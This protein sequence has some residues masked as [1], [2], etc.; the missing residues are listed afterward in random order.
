MTAIEIEMEPLKGNTAP[1]PPHDETQNGDVSNSKPVKIFYLFFFLIFER[2]ILISLLVVCCMT[3]VFRHLFKTFISCPKVKERE[4]QSMLSV[5]PNDG[6]TQ[7]RKTEAE[8]SIRHK[9]E[10][11]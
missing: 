11:L 1:K 4:S 10:V 8:R 6:E 3:I 7:R 9:Q 5:A 2:N